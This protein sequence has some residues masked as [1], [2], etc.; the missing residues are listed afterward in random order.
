MP[1]TILECAIEVG[2]TPDESG[3]FTVKTINDAGFDVIGGCISCR[4]TIAA[5]NAYPSQGGFW[6]CADCIGKD[7]FATTSDFQKWKNAQAKSDADF[8]AFTNRRSQ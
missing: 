7:G 6:C 4:A 8:N 2:A 3:S 1:V 5:Y